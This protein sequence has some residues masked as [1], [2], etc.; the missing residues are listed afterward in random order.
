MFSNQIRR[1][2]ASSQQFLVRDKYVWLD[3]WTFALR[4]KDIIKA[5]KY[6]QLRN[7]ATY[8]THKA[9]GDAGG[10]VDGWVIKKIKPKEQKK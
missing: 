9:F 10:K 4:S 3:M 6:E 1:H 5:K 2:D 7:E 8:L